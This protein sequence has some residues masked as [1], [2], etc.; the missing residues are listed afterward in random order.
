MRRSE[1]PMVS[2]ASALRHTRQPSARRRALSAD[3]KAP[4]PSSPNTSYSRS[5]RP[6]RVGHQVRSVGGTPS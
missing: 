3:P 5:S 2:Q 1:A 4:L 6:L